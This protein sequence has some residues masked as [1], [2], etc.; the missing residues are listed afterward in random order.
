MFY[1]CYKHDEYGSDRLGC[2][3]Y[4]IESAEKEIEIIRGDPG[5][6]GWSDWLKDAILWVVDE[7]G[8]I[9]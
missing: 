4:T 7:D 6:V 5:K 8:N 2:C 9:Y 3:Y 1:I